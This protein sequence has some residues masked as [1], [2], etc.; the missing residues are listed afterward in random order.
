MYQNIQ[1]IP[2]VRML[3]Q[4]LSWLIFFVLY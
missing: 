1:Y 2:G 3:S 4:I